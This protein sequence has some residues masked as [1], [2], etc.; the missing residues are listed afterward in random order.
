MP[1]GETMT[2]EQLSEA[3]TVGG[4]SVKE[5]LAVAPFRVAV[6]IATPSPT[7]L[8]AETAKFAT[9]VPAA[10]LTEAGV[11][12]KG[13]SSD[14]VTRA[15]PAGAARVRVTVHAADSPAPREVFVQVRE[16]GSTVSERLIDALLALPFN[17][18]VTA[19]V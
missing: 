2:G 14:R 3:G 12:M 7:V 11:A 13:L 5:A 6:R 10:T 17:A 1:L 9:E 15:P 8:D 19:A 4:M 18:A 16:L